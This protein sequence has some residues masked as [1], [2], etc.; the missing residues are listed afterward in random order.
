MD[1]ESGTTGPSVC[2]ERN[3]QHQPALPVLLRGT[4]LFAICDKLNRSEKNST[5][6]T[7]WTRRQE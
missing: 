1:P 4:G 3:R 6:T 2:K 5:G 7:G